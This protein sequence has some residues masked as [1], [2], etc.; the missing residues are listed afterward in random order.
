MYTVRWFGDTFG[1]QLR[2]RRVASMG[3]CVG[4]RFGVVGVYK[5]DKRFSNGGEDV[6]GFVRYEALWCG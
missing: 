2:R 6:L 5:S 4:G 3:R 1:M